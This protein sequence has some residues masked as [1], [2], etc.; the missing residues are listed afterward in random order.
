L[1]GIG[2][3]I[4]TVAFVIYLAVLLSTLLGKA[5]APAGQLSFPTAESLHPEAKETELIA[6]LRPWL[7]VA[8][9][10]IVVSYWVP[11]KQALSTPQGAPPYN[12]DNP[13]PLVKVK[14]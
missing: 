1:T 12:P 4:L 10:L 2:A 8:G 7:V 5:E 6:R 3:T 13:V 9:I 11:L 14:N